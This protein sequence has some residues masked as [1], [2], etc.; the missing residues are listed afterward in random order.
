MITAHDLMIEDPVA[1]P[2]MAKVRD[3]GRE[4]ERSMSGVPRRWVPAFLL[5][6]AVSCSSSPGTY[7][8]FSPADAGPPADGG[9]DGVSLDV[10]ADMGPMDVATDGRGS[11]DAPGDVSLGDTNDAACSAVELAASPT[12][13]AALLLVNRSASMG[14]ANKLAVAAQAVIQAV[15]RS[16]FDNTTIGLYAAP[17]GTVTGPACVFQLSVACATAT[18]PQVG[19]AL[20]GA[21]RLSD[22]SGVRHAISQ[23]LTSSSADKDGLG[24]SF[25]VYDAVRASLDALKAWNPIGRRLLVLATDG[26]FS[27][28]QFGSRPGYGDCNGC[29]HD[30]ED[31][32]NV[33]QMLADARADAQRPVETFVIGM[34]GADTNDARGCDAP[35]YSMRLALSAMA[36]AGSPAHVDPACDGRTY[37]KAG[38]DPHAGLS[39]RPHPWKLQRTEPRRRRDAR[40][41]SR[42]RL[43]LRASCD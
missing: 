11:T 4:M 18:S 28:G 35:P 20:A 9:G 33:I 41:P 6:G 5:L 38:A 21:L 19:L 13:A 29:D 43:P 7:V 31:P 40:A 36:Y 12:P 23:W 16:P 24:D 37:V 39:H 15:D 10:S 8:D 17:W 30:W 25:P 22:S 14:T 27:C 42:C 26:G 1:V 2:M 34:P 3:R 32:G